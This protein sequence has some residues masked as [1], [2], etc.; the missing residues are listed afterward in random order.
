M[1]WPGTPLLR[2]SRVGPTWVPLL[3]RWV[4]AAAVLSPAALLY[5]SLSL[6]FILEC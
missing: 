3:R 5:V 4:V 1:R 2:A 6:F